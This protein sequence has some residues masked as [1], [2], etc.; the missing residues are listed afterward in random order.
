[1][2]LLFVNDRATDIVELSAMIQ[3]KYICKATYW[4]STVVTIPADDHFVWTGRVET[5]A[6]EGHPTAIRCFAWIEM[7]HNVQRR[8]V[9]ILQNGLIVSPEV[10]V[11]AWLASKTV[12][13]HP[14]IDG[15]PGGVGNTAQRRGRE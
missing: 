8:F 13:I 2:Y 11:K 12:T 15:A 6:L 1:M 9:I 4:E 14:V 3:S 10:A 7:A 5:F